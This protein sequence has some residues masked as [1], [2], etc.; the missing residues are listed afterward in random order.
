MNRQPRLPASRGRRAI[1]GFTLIELLLVIAIIG[2]L[3]SILLPA[4]SRIK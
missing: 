2:L 4:F 1:G 3:L